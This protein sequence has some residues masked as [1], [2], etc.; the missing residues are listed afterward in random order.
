MNQ[1]RIPPRLS[2]VPV[3]EERRKPD[4]TM[5]PAGEAGWFLMRE[6]E[7][8]GLSIE[9]VSETIGIHPY[10]VEAIELG[11]M[12]NM[13]SRVEALE[14][15]AA[16]AD[17]LGFEPEPLLQHYVQF[18]PA[19]E[20][21]PRRHPANPAPL[22]SAKILTFGKFIKLPPIN[23]KLPSM[24]KM[25]K[26]PSMKNMPKLP[27]FPSGNGGIVASVLAAFIAFSA[28]TWTL[29]PGQAPQGADPQVAGVE[30]VDPMPTASTG[31]EEAEVVVK[32]QPMDGDASA[33]VNANEPVIAPPP[34]LDEDVLGAF[35]QENVA[36]VGE[37]A[38]EKQVAS[39]ETPA[40]SYGS[41]EES[42]R[43]VLKANRS[44]IWLL[45]EDKMG[46]RI[47]TQMLNKGD[48]FRVPNKP[49]LV[50]T[51]QDG[52]AITFMIDGV[53]KG[54]LGQ[55]GSVLAAESLDIKK[56]EERG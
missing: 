35:I 5:D 28:V 52:G 54:V 24:A 16:Y 31:A 4:G 39:V 26:M 13:P 6:R 19:P 15:I 1:N 41:K 29:V 18:L 22:T 48:E 12:T 17:F 44:N 40:R 32:E 11:N 36:G 9:Q 3:I 46:N 34:A 14:M 47:A 23:I 49:G 42:V 10:H 8:R 27:D 21:A 56:L 55:P 37:A 51:V 2:E 20:L 30:Q 7:D 45:I 50:A 38:E 43:L 25:P 33:T 53:E